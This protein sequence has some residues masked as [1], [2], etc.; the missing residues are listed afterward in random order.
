MRDAI[1]S[2]LAIDAAS[3]HPRQ[4]LDDYLTAPLEDID[5]VVAWWGIH[6]PPTLR[7]LAP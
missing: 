5:N 4:E 7:F 2:R 3:Q 1:K 6:S